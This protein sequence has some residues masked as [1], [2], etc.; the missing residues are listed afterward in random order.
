MAGRRLRA[1]AAGT[2][3]WALVLAGASGS[4][5]APTHT[6]AAELTRFTVV[7]EAGVSASA[8]TTAIEAAGGAVVARNAAAGTYQVTTRRSDFARRAAAATS[9]IGATGD[10]AIGAAPRLRDRVETEHLVPGA[11]RPG[12]ATGYGPSGGARAPVVGMDPLDERLWGLRMVR[13]DLARQRERGERGVTVGIL[14]TGVDATHPDLTPNFDTTLSRNFA[15]DIPSIDGAC[16]WAGCVDPVHVDDNGHG[17]HVAGTVG[18]AADGFGLSGVAPNVTLVALKG[19]QDS[20]YFFLD[21]VVNAIT[22]AADAGLDVVNMSFF[23]D[24]WLYNCG[25][26]AA[27]S[28]EARAEQRA[29]VTAMS[30]AMN[31]AHDRGVTMVVAMG[32]EHSDLG[33]PGVDES[34]PDTGPVAP[35]RRVV[36]NADCLMLPQEGPHAIGVSALGPSSRKADFSNYGL[37]RVTVAAPGGHFR[38][39][40]GTPTY[41]TAGNMILSSYPRGALQTEGIVDADGNIVAGFEETAFKRCAAD[42]RCGYY[43]HLQGTSMAAPHA[44]G[45]AA[46]IVSRFGTRDAD[47]G[48]LTMP[49]GDVERQLTRSAAARACPAPPLVSYKNEDRGPEF[50]ALCEGT[51][52][53]NGFYGSGIVDAFAAVGARR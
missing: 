30:R 25:S 9:L 3:G 19:G 48:G 41:R 47:L 22:Y 15:P 45:V 46:L 1:I 14:D 38:D 32:N 24:P 43:T 10:R 35:Y 7:A 31:Y 39:G 50:D 2:L 13:A 51:A 6:D 21:P 17:T 16:E 26:N 23:V 42:G 4:A 40:F 33:R 29:I 44:A 37:E 18:A 27:D 5:A 20:G 49:P 11:V 52:R 12:S 8:A 34:S 28:A 53:F 36:D